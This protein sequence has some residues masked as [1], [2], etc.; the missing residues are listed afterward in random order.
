MTN[1]FD[2]ATFDEQ[3]EEAQRIVGGYRDTAKESEERTNSKLYEF[4]AFVYRCG[5]AWYVDP[6]SYNSL[7]DAWQQRQIHEPKEGKNKWLPILAL[8][9]GRWNAEGKRVDF[10]DLKDQ[11]KWDR[12]QAMNKYA[13]ALRYFEEN[14]ILPD[15]V[16][17]TIRDHQNGLAGIVKADRDK[18]GVKRERHVRPEDLKLARSLKPLA[19][20]KASRTKEIGDTDFQMASGIWVDGEYRVITFVPKS[21]APAQRAVLEHAKANKPQEVQDANTE[22]L[23]KVVTLNPNLISRLQANVA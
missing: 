6:T 22:R 19:A 14:G 10:G 5:V 4:L 8:V 15:A 21:S 1:L 2:N 18:N 16:V 20:V 3:L 9:A 7:L 12:D 13:N 17:Q 23:A 11:R